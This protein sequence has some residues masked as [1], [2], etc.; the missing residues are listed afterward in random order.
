MTWEPTR[1]GRS[2]SRRSPPLLG[3]R[4]GPPLVRDRSSVVGRRRGLPLVG[5]VA[6]SLWPIVP[7]LVVA[8]RRSWPNA[9]RGRRPSWPAARRGP[10]A[11][12]VAHRSLGSSPVV[13]RH[14]LPLIVVDRRSW[15]GVRR[16]ARRSS[17]SSLSSSV[18]V[19][20][21][22]SWP[23]GRR[24]GPPLVGVVARRADAA[25]VAA[26]AAVVSA[27]APN[28]A[29]CAAAAA[30]AAAPSA[31]V[32]GHA[33][34]RAALRL[35]PARCRYG[36]LARGCYQRPQLW[37]RW[38]KVVVDRRSWPAAPSDLAVRRPSS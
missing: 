32:P 13:G 19:A 30:V 5:I 29:A 8:C 23:V 2:S 4:R 27:A 12:A 22:S 33:A 18:I 34:L 10:S 16:V 37:Q 9:R 38:Q 28:R 26:M 25:A 6:G 17:G 14:D 20:R 11:V 21:R 7:P 31:A 1:R 36:R 24:C 3:R 35:Q 15:P